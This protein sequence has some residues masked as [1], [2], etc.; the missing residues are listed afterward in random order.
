MGYRLTGTKAISINL[1]SL[2]RRRHRE[3]S[4]PFVTPLAEEPL[5]ASTWPLKKAKAG[6]ETRPTYCLL[7]CH[8]L[9]FRLHRRNYVLGIREGRTPLST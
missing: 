7:P 2:M 4:I 9:S 5:N 3:E 1:R 8:G 6:R